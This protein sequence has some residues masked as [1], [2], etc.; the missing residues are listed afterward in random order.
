[1]KRGFCA[2]E[3]LENRVEAA[4]VPASVEKVDER[5]CFFDFR[6]DA[7]F[8]LGSDPKLCRMFRGCVCFPRGPLFTG[9]IDDWVR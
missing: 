5:E 2:G 3:L 8:R 1:M 4:A 6:H 7:L 9:T